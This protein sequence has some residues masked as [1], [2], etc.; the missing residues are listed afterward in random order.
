MLRR[1]RS[2]T[3]ALMGGPI[4]SG[5]N[6][7]GN[8]LRLIFRSSVADPR[9]TSLI[10]ALRVARKRGLTDPN[11]PSGGSTWHLCHTYAAFPA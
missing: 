9:A 5:R 4:Y 11:K 1:V 6:R 2:M 7:M 10:V 8:L 3:T